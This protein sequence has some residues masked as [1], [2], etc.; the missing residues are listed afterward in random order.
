VNEAKDARGGALRLAVTTAIL[1]AIVFGA[2]LAA[3]I[4]WNRA[5]QVDEVEHLHAAYNM[6]DGRTLYR[7]FW[8]GHNPLL[9]LL[10]APVVQ[11]GDP[12]ASYHGAR[13][14]TGLLL[15]AIVALAGYCAC[16]LGGPSA[17]LGAMALALFHTTLVERGMEVRPDG[18]L[19]LCIIGALAIELRPRMRPLA[20]YT[21]EAVALGLGFLFTQ[22]AVFAT[23]AFGCWWL[24]QAWRARR[25]RLVLQPT[26]LWFAPLAV[27]LLVMVPFGCAR[28]FVQQNIVDAF[29]AGAGAKGRGRFSP[30]PLILHESLRNPAFVLLAIAGV[31]MWLRRRDSVDREGALFPALLA[32]M[33]TLSLWGNPFPWP[34]VHVAVLPVL[35]VAAGCALAALDRGSRAVVAIGVVAALATSL[36]RLLHDAARGTDAQFALLREVER[37]TAQDDRLFDLAGLY[38]RP[39]AYPAA[40]AMSGELL[41]YYARGGFARMVPLLRRNQCAGVMLNYRTAVLGEPERAFLRTHYVHY[42]RN[43]YLAGTE[44]SGAPR[45]ATATLEVLKPRVYRYD[46]DGAIT[47]DGAPFTRGALSAGAHT[48]IVQRASQASARLIVETPLPVPPREAPYADLYVNFD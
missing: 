6:R 5:Y 36:P 47:V 24:W 2:A 23:A 35:A 45:G 41:G 33:L 34:Y 37:V 21:A 13:V 48:V 10:I 39:D 3:A 44:L 12:V 46:G 14:V 1:A 32:L 28:E 22:K 17:A 18:G 7:D 31:A 29:F 11:V 8:Q 40:Y 25:P 20:R 9:Y 26:L 19:A 38:F 16:R 42:W 4:I 27:A 15:A 30:L 43:L